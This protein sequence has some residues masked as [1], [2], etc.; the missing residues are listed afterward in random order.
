MIKAWRLIPAGRICPR[1]TCGGS[2][3]GES[4]KALILG[5]V[6]GHQPRRP[7]HARRSRCGRTWIDTGLSGREEPPGSNSAVLKNFGA[8]PSGGLVC[9]ILERAFPVNPES[10]LANW[11]EPQKPAWIEARFQPPISPPELTIHT[12]PGLSP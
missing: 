6:V 5:F 7:R 2:N 3:Y 11:G 4:E 10:P 8:P 1:L 12:P 9:K